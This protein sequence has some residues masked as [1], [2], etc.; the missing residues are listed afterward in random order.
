MLSR[1]ERIEKAIE[2]DRADRA[3]FNRKLSIIDGFIKHESD[4]IEVETTRAVHDFL[5]KEGRF[6]G[7]KIYIPTGFPSKL[8]DP[9]RAMTVTD[10]DGVFILTNDPM[11]QEDNDELGSFIKLDDATAGVLSERQKELSTLKKT[12]GREAYDKHSLLV[13]IEAK[14]HVTKEKCEKKLRQME[15]IEGWLRDAVAIKQNASKYSK[16]FIKNVQMFG[17]DKYDPMPLLFMGGPYWDEEAVHYFKER[18]SEVRF[19]D[20]LGMIQTSGARYKV[21]DNS[22]VLKTGGGRKQVT[23]NNEV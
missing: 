7:Y 5:L 22:R 8:Y 19:K 4:S 2:A 21:F 10:L 23:K 15:L 9:V 16:R 20:R 17:F 3:D 18:M 13:I 14:H 1:I 12:L 11:V 6:Y